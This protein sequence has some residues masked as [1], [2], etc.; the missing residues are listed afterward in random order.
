VGEPE[1]VRAI[2]S[3]QSVSKPARLTILGKT[4]DFA[5]TLSLEFVFPVLLC[6]AICHL[7][8]R[9]IAGGLHKARVMLFNGLRGVRDHLSDD[10]AR[11]FPC[12]HVA[13]KCV[14]QTMW[15]R[16]GQFFQCLGVGF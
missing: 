15:T 10:V 16:A 7:V 4:H 1:E 9:R 3:E 2:L 5:A 8:L 12:E 6:P 14:P 13:D 11:G